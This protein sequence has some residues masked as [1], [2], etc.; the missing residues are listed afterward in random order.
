[1]LPFK[2][3]LYN[4]VS[5]FCF[6]ILNNQIIEYFNKNL[7][8]NRRQKNQIY[9]TWDHMRKKSGGKNFLSNKN[10]RLQYRN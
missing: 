6:K 8:P 9:L 3:R 1:M 10:K 5:F 4:R 2:M 7:E